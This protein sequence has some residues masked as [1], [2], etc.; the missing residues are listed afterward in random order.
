MSKKLFDEENDHIE[1]VESASSFEE[2]DVYLDDEQDDGFEFQQFG[3]FA[4]DADWIEKNN[5]DVRNSYEEFELKQLE[6]NLYDIYVNA[7]FFDKYEGNKKVLKHELVHVYL[8]FIDRIEDPS[9][10]SPVDKFIAIASF[11][12]MN[13][14][15]MYRELPIVYKEEIL[16]EL[17]KKYNMISKDKRSHRLF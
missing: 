14:E 7:P 1:E 9:R 15:V 16:K 12:K 4:V 13:F 10:F 3:K 11:M 2:L 5:N 6:E 17:N 8:Y